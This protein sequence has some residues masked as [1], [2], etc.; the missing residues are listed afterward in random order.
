MIS[1]STYWFISQLNHPQSIGFTPINSSNH[2][3]LRVLSFSAASQLTPYTS[4]LKPQLLPHLRSSSLKLTSIPI[5]CIQI[6]SFNISHGVFPSLE[7]FY[8]QATRPLHAMSP[9]TRSSCHPSC[10]FLFNSSPQLDR[11]PIFLVLKSFE[12]PHH[13]FPIST[14]LEPSSHRLP[15]SHQVNW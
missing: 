7:V 4:R 15:W 14:G 10:L 2:K 5:S 9:S 6:T 11:A 13:H 12:C 3:I 1:Q 8:R